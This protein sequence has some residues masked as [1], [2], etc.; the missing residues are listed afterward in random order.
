MWSRRRS[1]W[2]RASAESICAARSVTAVRAFRGEH[3]GVRGGGGCARNRDSVEPIQSAAARKSQSFLP[4]GHYGLV[5]N[6]ARGGFRSI[7]RLFFV[8]TRACGGCGEIGI[9]S[10]SGVPLG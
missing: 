10:Q 2:I 8:R 5:A 9:D 7:G 6:P 4:A 1:V 3:V